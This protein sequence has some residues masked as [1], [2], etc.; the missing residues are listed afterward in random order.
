MNKRTGTGLGPN[1]YGVMEC[2]ECG[3]RAFQ[4]ISK[5]DNE[6]HVR[7]GKRLTQY[8]CLQCG[9]RHGSIASNLCDLGEEGWRDIPSCGITLDRDDEINDAGW[10][11]WDG[12]N[13]IIRY[14]KREH[15]QAESYA[16]T[17]EAMMGIDN[18]LN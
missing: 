15:K 5:K 13:R 6:S 4:I 18:D 11:K 14:W 7:K 10:L 2:A 9:E 17:L 16:K 12:L 8:H 1:T 3:C